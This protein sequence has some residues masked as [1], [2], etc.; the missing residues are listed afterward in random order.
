VVGGLVL[1]SVVALASVI[2][3]FGNEESSAPAADHRST[4]LQHEYASE[5]A[6]DVWITVVATTAG[7]REITITWGPWQRSISQAARGRRTYV[8]TKYPT[9]QGDQNVPVHVRVDPAAKVVFGSGER[10]HHAVD[11]NDGWTPAPSH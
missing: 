7:T 6:G 1:G 3:I 10:P 2:A 5:Y 9:R 11:V 8:F 4:T